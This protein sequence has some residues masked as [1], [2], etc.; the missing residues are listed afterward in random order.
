VGCSNLVGV[1]ETCA[2]TARVGEDCISSVDVA[3]G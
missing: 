1:G 2:G 3:V